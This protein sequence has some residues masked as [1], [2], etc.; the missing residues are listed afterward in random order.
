MRA[1]NVEDVEYVDVNPTM[2]FKDGDIIVNEDFTVIGV[3]QAELTDRE[4]QYT[5]PSFYIACSNGRVHENFDDMDCE[6]PGDY[7]FAT[8]EETEIFLKEVEDLTDLIWCPNTKMLEKRDESDWKVKGHFYPKTWDEAVKNYN[9]C[10]EL[11]DELVCCGYE[12]GYSGTIYSFA[13][14][15]LLYDIYVEGIENKPDDV[16]YSVVVNPQGELDLR[17]YI[18]GIRN[19]LLT[20]RYQEQARM[21]MT[22]FEEM[23]KKCKE[24]V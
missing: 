11:E 14:L 17:P 16:V 21:F 5:F 18:Y 8:D 9:S 19:S 1:D 15:K 22:Y 13:Q 20:F 10:H 24:L 2:E 12:D 4:E 3:F 7:R 6:W 23:I